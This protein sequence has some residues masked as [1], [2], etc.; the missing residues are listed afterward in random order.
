MKKSKDLDILQDPAWIEFYRENPVIAAE[1]LLIRNERPLHLPPHQR[2][3]LKD[4]WSGVPFS[5]I[6]MSR[7]GG[8][9]A[10]IAIYLI[11][12]AVLYPGER[13][14][15]ISGSFRPAKVAVDEIIRFYRD[16]PI[17]QYCSKKPPTRAND[18]CRWDIEDNGSIIKALPLGDGSNVRG[19]RFYRLFLD[20]FP[21][22]DEQILSTVIIPMLATRKDPTAPL[23]LYDDK[24]QLIMAST[25]TWQFSWA[26]KYYLHYKEEAEKGNPLYS[27]HEFDYRDLGDFMEKEN[28][29]FAKKTSP[30]IIFL[31]EYMNVWAKDSLGWFPAS[32][33]NKIK[34]PWCLPEPEGK[35]GEEYVLGIDP[36]R[37][38]DLFA[39]CVMRLAN[40]ERRVVN[41]I[42]AH[43]AT[44]PEM[45][46]IIRDLMR[47]YNVVRIAMDYGGGGLAVRDQLAI[48]NIFYDVNTK[49]NIEEEPI[50]PID[51]KEFPGKV[52]KR[53]LDLVFFSPKEIYQMNVGLKSDMEH[54][55][56]IMPKK[57]VEGNEVSESIF[58]EMVKLEDEL[59]AIQ[60]TVK[61][62]GVLHFDTPSK[63][64]IK[65]RYTALLLANKAAKD[66]LQINQKPGS[67][68]LATGFWL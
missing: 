67:Q 2:I 54:K 42:V 45:A 50:L 47:K 34:E 28:I 17:I 37:E 20:E 64:M 26:Y 36:A 65:D 5:M 30:R 7:G 19:Q 41:I 23:E 68:K 57:P 12:R 3:I 43:K 35:E 56:V 49:E 62:S 38:S 9:S 40:N 39:V 53:I 52:G 31:M 10:L 66:Y 33:I 25:A 1:D 22:I 51:T 4:L 44:F 24:N 18:E 60:A 6:I 8:K 11:L 21:T 27:L 15:I 63:R 59:I 55:R 13:L 32:L 48:P 61:Q 14:G 46:Q 29:E 16:S 58:A